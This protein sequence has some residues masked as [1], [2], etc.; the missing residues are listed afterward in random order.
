MP[1]DRDQVPVWVEAWQYQCCGDDFAVGETVRWALVRADSSHLASL[2]G[3]DYPDWKTELQVARRGEEPGSAGGP[4]VELCSGGLVVRVPDQEL[5]T[6]ADRVTIGLLAEEH[7]GAVGEGAR[8]TVGVVRSI[9]LVHCRY[10]P[11]AG[12]KTHYPVPGSARLVEVR[13]S[14]VSARR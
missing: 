3:E 10:A 1:I 9:R 6:R 13:S 12:T 2:L 7:H 4:T 8:P 11:L 5:L 14:V